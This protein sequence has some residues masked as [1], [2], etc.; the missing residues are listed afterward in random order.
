[1]TTPDRSSPDPIEVAD[2]REGDGSSDPQHFL[3]LS[4]RLVYVVLMIAVSTLPFISIVN[5]ADR[6]L[7]FWDYAGPILATLALAAIVL[8]LDIMNPRKGL[9]NVFGLY[10]AVVAGLFAALAVGALIDLI[11]DAWGLGR[12]DSALK[13]LTLL[14]LAVGLS[15]CYLAVSIVLT[16]KDNIRMVVPYVEFSRQVRGIRPMVLDTSALI[17]GRINSFGQTGFLDAPLLV[18]QFVIDEMHRLSDSNEQAKRERGRRG[19]SNLRL[20]Q[21]STRTNVTIDQ[22]ETEEDEVD[23]ALLSIAAE[24]NLRIVTTDYNLARVAEIRDVAVLNLNDLSHLLR[25]H[26]VPGEEMPLEIMRAGESKDQGVGYMPDGTM[27]VVENAQDRIGQEVMVIINNAVQTS[28]GRLVFARL[29]NA[30]TSGSIAQAATSQ[31]RH[32][33]DG[34]RKRPGNDDHSGRSPRR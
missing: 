18:P 3:L 25:G 11:A 19:L 23:Q 32:V 10:L 12:G 24:K 6:G 28:A 33:D 27:V 16:T 7:V 8:L 22:V 2:Q 13:Y 1:M 30:D 21:D 34:P 26:V 5:P 15:L 9:A 4:T 20:L 17:D 14:K 31:A 29:A